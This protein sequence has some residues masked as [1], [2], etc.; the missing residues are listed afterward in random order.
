[1]DRKYIDENEIEIRYL[2]NQ[3]TPQELEEFEVCLMENEDLLERLEIQ[4]ALHETLQ[5]NSLPENSSDSRNS[6]SLDE[7]SEVISKLTPIQK[8]IRWISL[9][10]PAYAV[11]LSLV[12]TAS[13][14]FVQRAG[15]ENTEPL[16]L[17]G[18]STIATR[19]SKLQTELDLSK[20]NGRAAVMIKL[21]EV[22]YQ[23]YVLDV[24]SEDHQR[25]WQSDLFKVGTLKDSLVLLPSRISKNIVKIKVLGVDKAG[26]ENEVEF[27]HYSENCR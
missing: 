2:R 21:K 4:Q 20:V 27:C 25:I 7:S 14:V 3:L 9:P 13:L 17:V 10:I 15:T 6:K 24:L 1:M 5:S 18:F 22:K 19:G 23:Y 26:K 11:L 16:E 8:L 12:G